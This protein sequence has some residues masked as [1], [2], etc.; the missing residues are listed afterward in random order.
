MLHP[1]VLLAFNRGQPDPGAAQQVEQP[2]GDVANAAQE[3]VPNRQASEDFAAVLA[4][5]GQD[6]H[7]LQPH[8]ADAQNFAHSFLSLL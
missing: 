2:H 6:H 1:A 4:C 7:G 3:N 8:H 5:Q